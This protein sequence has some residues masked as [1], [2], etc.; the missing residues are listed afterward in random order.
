MGYSLG[1][2]V[3]EDTQHLVEEEA[4]CLLL[5]LVEALDNVD[6]SPLS[7]VLQHYEPNPL[8]GSEL[9]DYAST[10]A[11]LKHFDDVRVLKLLKCGQLVYKYLSGAL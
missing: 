1:V 8:Q 11:V 7:D 5:Q 6:H 9:S 2:D 10:D 3:L 4:G